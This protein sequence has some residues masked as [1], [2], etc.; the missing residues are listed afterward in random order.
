MG[1][2]RSWMTT[3]CARSSRCRTRSASFFLGLAFQRGWTVE[4][5]FEMTK[6][7]RWFL[8]NI[9]EIVDARTL[10]NTA[11]L[12][13]GA[14]G[15]SARPGCAAGRRPASLHDGCLSSAASTNVRI[16]RTRRNCPHWEQKARQL[17]HHLPPRRLGALRFAPPMVR[18]PNETWLANSTPSHGTQQNRPRIRA[19][20]HVE[21]RET[22]A[23]TKATAPAPARSERAAEI[24]AA[25]YGAFRRRPI[26]ARCVR[27]H[28]E[29]C[30]CRSCS[31][32]PGARAH[33]RFCTRGNF[34][35]NQVNK[36]LGTHGAAVLDGVST[37]LVRDWDALVNVSRIHR[38]E[39]GKA[40]AR[41]EGFDL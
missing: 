23:R 30:P 31:R 33:R 21:G 36:Q 22:M 37:G 12:P 4:E 2:M 11:A 19:A 16:I 25:R 5:I 7:D 9:R 39:S 18:R 8:E 3:R 38:R 14:A 10:R 41:V 15:F 1:R 34:T 28:A 29:S 20:L 35:A 6:I 32:K 40:L 26:R 13:G 17:L 24:V 27:G